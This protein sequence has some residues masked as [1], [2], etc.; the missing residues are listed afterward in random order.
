MRQAPPRASRPAAPRPTPSTEARTARRA[1]KR[2]LRPARASAAKT[3]PRS[4]AS[5]WCAPRRFLEAARRDARV[6]GGSP[7]QHCRRA[8]ARPP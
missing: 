2:R 8:E 4:R 6:P 3:P 1:E 7:L 5:G